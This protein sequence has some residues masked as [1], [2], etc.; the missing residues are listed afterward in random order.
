MLSVAASTLQAQDAATVVAPDFIAATAAEITAVAADSLTAAA[1]DSL[2][3][4]PFYRKGIIG[5]IYN[6]FD[7]SNEVKE[8]KDFDISFIGGPY[9]SSDTKFGLALVAGAQYRQDKTDRTIPMS[10]VDITARATTSMFFELGLEGTHI[11]PRDRY[12]LSYDVNISY[13]KT[14]FWGIG[15]D[16][17]INDANESSYKYVAS[18]AHASFQWRI[19]NILYIG[20]QLAFDYI[21]GR[22]YQKPEL[23]EGLP[24]KTFNVGAGFVAQID[25]RD[26]LTFPYRGINLKLEQ[27]F[28]PR[29]LANKYAF[30]LTELTFCS[31]N[32]LWRS[33]ILATRLHAR[34]TYGNTPWGLLSTLG[35]S[36]NMR[37]Y[38]EG[39]FRDKSEM[40]LTVEL[41]QH[42][43]R[44]NS[45]VVWV[46]AGTVFP[47]F[48]ALRWRK[49]LP[50]FGFG[51]R[52]EFKKRMNVRADIGFGRHEKGL[53]IS[54]NE[55]F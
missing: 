23:W 32:R 39:R 1:A 36:H 19:A 30:S 28:N 13:V 22:E 49:V 2:A 33:G 48:S 55:A 21:N 17:D 8:D 54:I 34:F 5:K 16:M 43:W 18:Q 52:W 44:R 9:Y 50:N 40:D 31:Y 25:T 45:V 15:Y 10:N 46:G 38:F 35:G 51:Y 12:R 47:E 14:K 6:Y 53:V 29:F 42:V 11:F 37:G 24:D 20:P 7:E 3:A 27:R 26:N 41:R 4:L